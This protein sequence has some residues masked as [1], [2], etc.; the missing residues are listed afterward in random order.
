M[1]SKSRLT[2]VLALAAALAPQTIPHPQAGALPAI[3]D[4]PAGHTFKALLD[5]FNSSDS[6]VAARSL[7]C[8]HS[9]YSPPR[10]KTNLTT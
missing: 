4:T 1:F 7:A 10:V 2:L 6:V 9:R 3:P 5:A 8:Q